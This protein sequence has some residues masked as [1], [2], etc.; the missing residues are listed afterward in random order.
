MLATRH[1]ADTCSCRSVVIARSNL[2]ALAAKVVRRDAR[3]TV[4]SVGETGQIG[5]A[6]LVA[7]MAH[8]HVTVL[9]Q[10]GG[11]LKSRLLDQLGIETF[12]GLLY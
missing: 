2:A 5:V 10:P 1:P 12:R 9:E 4:K 8:P 6:Q 11:V 7:D 3:P